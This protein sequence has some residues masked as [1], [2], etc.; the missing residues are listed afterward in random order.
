LFLLFA[1]IAVCSWSVTAFACDQ[2][3]GT[4]ATAA[5]MGKGTSATY[6]ASTCAGTKGAQS[7]AT[8]SMEGCC[9]K[10]G[11]SATTASVTGHSDK[12]SMTAGSCAMHGAK[13]TAVT[14]GATHGCSGAEGAT[15]A[16]SSCAMHGN[17]AT[18]AGS[19]CA[20]HGNTATAAGSSCP[21]HANSATAANARH[22][23]CTFC[24]ELNGC[25]QEMR[26]LGAVAQVVPL[27]N[28]VMFVYTS[29]PARVRAIQSAMARRKDQAAIFASTDSGDHL[30]NDCKAMRGAAASGKLTREVVN[31]DSGCL[32]LMTSS[33][34]AI[35]ARIHE[36]AGVPTTRIKS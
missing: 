3:K 10:S 18:A 25:D 6:A 24:E 15:A 9:A 5:S 20:A 33:D 14:A 8:A 21:A 7:A 26:S 36:L 30:C 11:A 27:K 1:A 34:P 23:G 12:N 2:E 16:G 32:T 35:V 13:A 22:A 29:D 31:I 19:S 28:G 17:T 4:K